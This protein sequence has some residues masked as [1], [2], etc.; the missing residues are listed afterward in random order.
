MTMDK[1]NGHKKILLLEDDPNLGLVIQDNLE[2]RGYDVELCTNGVAGREQFKKDKYDLCLVDVMMPKKDGFTFARELRAEGEN[3]PIIFL[4]ARSLKKDRIEGL[5]IGA[6]DYVTKPFSMEELLLRIEAVLR[7]ISPV[8]P[9]EE[10]EMIHLIGEFSFDGNNHLLTFK[11]KNQKLTTKES[12]LL[13][14]LCIH[15]N[16]I[17]SRDVALKEVWHSD[18]YFASRSM[19]VYISRLRSYLKKG[20]NIEIVTIHG[21][22]FKLVVTE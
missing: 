9:A 13:R 5:Q 4:T 18:N 15:K 19:D 14:L 8:P 22:G 17:L 10:P 12:D 21:K 6:D 2:M 3:V 1:P 11:G 16:T 7:R 20:H